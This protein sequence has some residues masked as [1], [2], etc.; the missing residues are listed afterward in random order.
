M[1]SEGVVVVD[2]RVQGNIPVNVYQES[3]RIMVA[4]PVPGMEPASI[5]VEIQGRHVTI[6]TELRGP[7]QERTQLYVR[8]EWS[9]GPYHRSVDVPNWVD[10]ERANAT[11]DNG[12]LVLI[13][14]TAPGPRN[15][16]LMLSKV[17]TIKGRRI[18]HVGQEMKPPKRDRGR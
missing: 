14:P 15:G 10:V 16:E 8:R 13:L 2:R 1:R 17:G 6:D 18:G 3:D 4:A 9:A 12:I 5:K 7:G 11:Y